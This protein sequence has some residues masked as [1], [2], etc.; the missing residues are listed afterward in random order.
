MLTPCFSDLMGYLVACCGLEL[1]QTSTSLRP[2]QSSWRIL[3]F[4]VQLWKDIFTNICFLSDSFELSLTLKAGHTTRLCVC[5]LSA[6]SYVQS[7]M[8]RHGRNLCHAKPCIPSSYGDTDGFKKQQLKI[9]GAVLR[10]LPQ[11]WP[12]RSTL[13]FYYICQVKAKISTERCLLSLTCPW[14][15]YCL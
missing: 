3:Y 11:V 6:S 5:Y 10:A 2:L 9:T 1:R 13:G 12:T 4:I 8:W 14:L 15:V 7:D